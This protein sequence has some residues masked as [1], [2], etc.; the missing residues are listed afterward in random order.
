MENE[1][2]KEEKED[3]SIRYIFFDIETCQDQKMLING[4]RVSGK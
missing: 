1:E 4:V 2:E 3:E